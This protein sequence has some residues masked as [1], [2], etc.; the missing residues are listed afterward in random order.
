MK[1]IILLIEDNEDIRESM[2]EILDLEGYTVI[3]ADCGN[4]GLTL[5]LKNQPDLVICDIVMSGRD[6]YS[7][8]KALQKDKRTQYIPVIFSTA[9]SE[10]RDQLKAATMGV[11]DY[12]VK[13]FNDQ[14]LIRCVK[15]C[16]A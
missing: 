9:K 5:A 15:K 8:V 4:A 16:L 6:G 12:L 13:P 3:T 14:E 10:R 1:K 7:V 11:H 2:A